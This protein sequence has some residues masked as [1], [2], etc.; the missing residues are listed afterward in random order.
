MSG[1]QGTGKDT[2]TTL[3]SKIIGIEYYLQISNVDA[4]F[5]NFNKSQECKLLTKINELSD[6]GSHFEKHNELK[7]KITATHVTIEPKGFDSYTIDHISRYY[8]FSNK[9]N[10]LIVEESD[11]RF[12]MIKTNNEMANNQQ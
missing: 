4:F 5:K 9:E 8:A 3:L 2:W 12:L 10:I 11:R 1:K 7:E 6:K